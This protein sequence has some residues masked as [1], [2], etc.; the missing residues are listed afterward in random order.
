[1]TSAAALHRRRKALGAKVRVPA[2]FAAGSAPPRNYRANVFPF[3]ANSHFLYFTATPIEGSALMIEPG[4]RST[5]FAP[6][7]DPDDA[8]W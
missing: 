3:R 4:G 1:M 2:L 7:P 8:V 5:L 6:P